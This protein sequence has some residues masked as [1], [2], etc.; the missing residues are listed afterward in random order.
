MKTATFRRVVGI[1]GLVDPRTGRVMYVGQSVDCEYR[2]RKHLRNESA[3]NPAKSRWLRELDVL[4]LGPRLVVLE[5][6]G[7]EELDL[8]ERRWLRQLKADGQAEL[9]ITS[10]GVSRTASPSLNAHIDDLHQEQQ[11][12]A[13]IRQALMDSANR[14]FVLVGAGVPNLIRNAVMSLDKAADKLHAD[15]ERT[16]EGGRRNVG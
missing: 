14:L 15:T 12:L 16:S 8:A 5:E 7:R 9:N 11:Y 2:F 6:C 1:Y 13:S 4:D 3:D 10:G